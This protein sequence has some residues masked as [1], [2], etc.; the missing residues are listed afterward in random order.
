MAFNSIEEQSENK[1]KN[2]QC[3]RFEPIFNSSRKPI[4]VII[5]ESIQ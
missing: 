3:K 2:I 4:E 5:F 1:Y